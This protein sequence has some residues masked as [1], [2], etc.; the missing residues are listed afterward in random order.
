MSVIAG[1][2]TDGPSRA[3]LALVVVLVGALVAA[4]GCSGL[5]DGGDG[6]TPTVS[7]EPALDV[8][9][10]GV[11]SVAY[12]DVNG[13]LED[14]ELRS[15]AN[16][17]YGFSDSGPQ[18]VEETLDRMQ[19]NTTLAISDLQ[20]VTGYGHTNV[21]DDEGGYGAIVVSADWS[22]QQVVAEIENGSD[23]TMEA[24]T[25]AGKQ[26]W[27]PTDGEPADE[28]ASYVG[29]L[30]ETRFV[31]GTEVA[32][33]DALRVAS[34][35]ADAFSGELRT[36]FEDTREGS[37]VRYATTIPQD[38]VDPGEIG[39]NTDVFN[40]VTLVSGA[41]YVA[42]GNVTLATTM[43]FASESAATDAA[44]V[45]D[46][47]IAMYRGSMATD[48]NT[49]ALL[50]DEN[51]SVEA[52]VTDVTITT[53]NSAATINAALES[54]YETWFSFGSTTTASATAAPTRISPATAPTG[55]ATA[56]ATLGPAG[57]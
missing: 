10:A 40:E 15:I 54:I 33:K 36:A 4:P 50:S 52:S 46:G 13:T 31:V 38:E 14:E 30:S 11:D 23:V 25:V 43:T 28:N 39:G 42:D 5:F 16:T 12:V 44:D 21:T 22:I 49:R 48:P 29:K 24:T 1:G 34:G 17:L 20:A 19:A 26:F 37:Y 41:Q 6:G 53:S 47:A 45:M 35:N 9:P 57:G 2:R 8:V 55:S 32:T 51:L 7:D 3:R 56:P 18:T 27:R